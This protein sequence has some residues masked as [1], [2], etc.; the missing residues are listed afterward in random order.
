MERHQ[1]EKEVKL[2]MNDLVSDNAIEVLSNPVVSAMLDDQLILSYK[3]LPVRLLPKKPITG[4]I[5]HIAATLYSIPL[6]QDFLRLVRFS[7]T[8]LQRPI[9]ENDLV[10]EGTR[11]HVFMYN[12]YM[13]GGNSRVRGVVVKNDSIALQFNSTESGSVKDSYYIAEPTIDEMPEEI[14]DPVA[15][16]IASAALMILGRTDASIK[17]Q[18]KVNEFIISIK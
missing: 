2:R 1:L 7:T 16:F 12:L 10:G 13:S 14:V 15:W 5:S 3:F 9:Y 11:D 4:E 8:K 18:Q 6:P 17:A